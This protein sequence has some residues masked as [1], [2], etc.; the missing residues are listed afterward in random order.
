MSV[1]NTAALPIVAFDPRVVPVLDPSTGATSVNIT[2]TATS[3]SSVVNI[4]VF[5]N[6]VDQGS[7]GQLTSTAWSVPVIL[8]PGTYLISAQAFGLTGASVV[9]NAFELITGIE[10][11]AYSTQELSLNS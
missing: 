8:E 1:L 5:A 6:D 11:Q 9:Q 10:G 3:P 7:T 2:G 4:D